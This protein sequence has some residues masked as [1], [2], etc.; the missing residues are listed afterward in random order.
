[1][2]NAKEKTH[3]REEASAWAGRKRHQILKRPLCVVVII[4]TYLLLSLI[5]FIV[6]ICEK[7][8]QLLLLF[9]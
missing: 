9:M 8:S 5:L 4:I 7:H 3:S 2:V 6:V 1:V